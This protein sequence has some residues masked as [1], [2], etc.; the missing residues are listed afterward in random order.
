M[1]KVLS[2]DFFVRDSVDVAWD[3]IGKY[4]VSNAASRIITEFEAYGGVEDLASHAR[5]GKTIRNEV[6]WGEPGVFMFI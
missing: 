5:F 2:Q 6:M 3:L 4:L 1:K